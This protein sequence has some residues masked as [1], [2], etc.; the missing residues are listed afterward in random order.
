MGMIRPVPVKFD[1][2]DWRI[3]LMLSPAQPEFVDVWVDDGSDGPWDD[4]GAWDYVKPAEPEVWFNVQRDVLEGDGVRWA[5]GNETVHIEDLVPDTGTMTFSLNNSQANSAGLLSHYTPDHPNARQGFDIGTPARLRIAYQGI[6]YTRWVG[7][8]T[9]I[10]IV[11]GIFSERKVRVTAKDWW[12][13]ASNHILAV[14][15]ALTD[16]RTDQ[17]I[18]ALLAGMPIQPPGGTV[19]DEGL[20]ILSLVFD[21]IRN[22]RTT[23]ATELAK[24]MRSG[25]RDRCFIDANGALRYRNREADIASTE[26][27]WVLDGTM[28]DVQVRRS[29]YDIVNRVEV[30]ANA[31]R[32]GKDIGVL[33]SYQERTFIAPGQTLPVR[34]EF[35]DPDNPSVRVGAIDLQQLVPGLDYKLDLEPEIASGTP[36]TP[37]ILRPDGVGF[38]TGLGAEA[39]ALADED[40][41]TGDE[42]TWGHAM[43]KRSWTLSNPSVSAASNAAVTGVK[44][45]VRVKHNPEAGS[46]EGGPTGG[47]FILYMGARLNGVDIPINLTGTQQP[48]FSGFASGFLGAEFEIPAPPGGGEWNV[49]AVKNLEIWRYWNWGGGHIVNPRLV[50]LEVHFTYASA[51]IDTDRTSNFTVVMTEGGSGADLAVKN[52]GT[53]GAYTTKLQVRGRPVFKDNAVTVFEHDLVSIN[54]TPQKPGIGVRPETLNMDYQGDAALA[55]L[56]AGYYL[57]LRKAARNKAGGVTFCANL[58]DEHM[59]NAL[60]REIGDRIG[61]VEEMT[62]Q[63]AFTA[64][65]K[66]NGYHIIGERGVIEPGKIIRITWPLE[67][68]DP[69]VFWHAGIPGTQEVGI[70]NVVGPA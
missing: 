6:W 46:I 40:D 52:N 70:T 45:I 13:E 5:R 48:Y 65:A 42:A 35:S 1:D 66:P 16:V 64:D 19:L 41:A 23:A 29:R 49:D 54:G 33:W 62:A 26:N 9:E 4:N 25:G 43:E 7:R 10:E 67:P 8:I 17:A 57:S 22:G 15:P 37:T 59:N 53:D 61:L 60:K 31:R 50:K 32:V 12:E 24:L 21:D 11:D 58:S 69:Q 30:T 63:K 55:Q 36:D 27:L 14:V 34:A 44:V 2:I 28:Q 39:P 18:P 51:P 20:D 3:E 47:F 68:A 38:Y 56:Y